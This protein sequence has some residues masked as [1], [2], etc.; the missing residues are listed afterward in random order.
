MTAQRIRTVLILASLAL[1]APVAQAA[2]VT[3]DVAEGVTSNQ[4]SV[5]TGSDILN[6]TGLGT[7]V[8]NAANS[9]T[10]DTIIGASLKHGGALRVDAGAGGSLNPLSDLVF[11]DLNIKPY[12]QLNGIFIY[13][14]TTATGPTSQTFLSLNNER[15]HGE[16]TVQITRTAEQDVTLR[17][18]AFTSATYGAVVINFAVVGTGVVNGT[19]AKI[20]LDDQPAGTKII[21]GNTYFNGGDF[22]Y[23]DAAGFIRGI[24]YSGDPDSATSAGGAAFAAT[25]NQEITGSITAQGAVTLG[26]NTGGLHNATL[27]IVGASD[28]TMLPSCKLTL[29]APASSG[30]F[31][32][33]KTGGGKST[34]SGGAGSELDAASGNLQPFR[35]DGPTDVLEI[36]IPLIFLTGNTSARTVKSGAG[37][38]IIS[39][40][41]LLSNSGGRNELWIHGGVFEIGGSA[42][43]RAVTDNSVLGD[44][45]NVNIAKGAL[46]RYNSVNTLSTVEGWIGGDG[47][48]EVAAGKL[49]VTGGGASKPSIYTGLTTISGGTLALSLAGAITNSASIQICVGGSFDVTGIS[50]GTYAMPAAPMFIFDFDPTGG[51]SAGVLDATGKTLDISAG[52]VTLNVPVA[53]DDP[54][55]VLAKYTSLAGAEFASLTGLPGGSSIDYAYEGNKI[56]LM[57]AKKGTILL[58]K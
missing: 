32:I 17:F 1:L 28:L 26:V 52:K 16:N 15:G 2:T 18:N 53:L 50:S 42:R 34:I 4:P 51:G 8:I 23:Y 9:Y 29:D 33:L 37:K 41:L 58:L 30:S 38:L 36:A 44:L 7:L 10:N 24:N 45:P 47:D 56:A 14:N 39:K 46:L 12:K 25:D 13:D 57:V 27:K 6:K 22:A 21:K 19:N 43:F 40:D 20:I 11:T 48:L 31:G 35:V 49:T 54:V 5:L 3:Y 55:Y